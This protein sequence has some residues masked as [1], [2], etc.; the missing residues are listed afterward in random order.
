MADEI[1][2]QQVSNEDS[3]KSIDD[4]YIKSIELI[5]D[6]IDDKSST[7]YINT[8][9]ANR[10]FFLK[11]AIVAKEAQSTKIYNN[12]DE[13]NNDLRSL[14]E[15]GMNSFNT[16]NTS[17]DSVKW[18]KYYYHV[19]EESNKQ[20]I[21]AAEA[22]IK[23]YGIFDGLNKVYDGNDIPSHI[24]TLKNINDNLQP[25]EFI[26]LY[27]DS[28]SINY[29]SFY[30]EIP[31]IKAAGNVETVAP[32]EEAPVQEAPLEEA[33]V[34][35][36]PVEEAPVEE[37]PVQEAPVQ[38]APVQE[39]P[40]EE[41]PVQEAPVEETGTETPGPISSPKPSKTES[42]TSLPKT[43]YSGPQEQP[44]PSTVDG[45]NAKQSRSGKG[46]YWNKNGFNTFIHP[47]NLSDLDDDGKKLPDDWLSTAST[48]QYGKFPIGT[49][50]YF[51]KGDETQW[52]SPNYGI[53]PE[54]WTVDWSTTQNK[55]YYASPNNKSQ[56]TFPNNDETGEGSGTPT[57]Q[58][59]APAAP[60]FIYLPEGW[61]KRISKTTGKSLYYKHGTNETSWDLDKIPGYPEWLSKQSDEIKAEADAARK[62]NAERAANPK[63]PVEEAAAEGPATPTP[64]E[65]TVAE[66]PATVAEAPATVAPTSGATYLPPKWYERVSKSTGKTL[67]FNNET[68]ETSWNLDGIPGYSEWINQQGDEIQAAAEEAEKRDAE[69][70]STPVV[71]VQEETPSEEI[72]PTP[73][74]VLPA[75]PA[76]PADAIVKYLPQNWYERV[77]KKFGKTLY[78]NPLTKETHGTLDKIPGYAEWINRQPQEIKDAAE[79]ARK[80]NI[81]RDAN[82]SATQVVPVKEEI[83]PNPI[84]QAPTPAKST[85]EAFY[86]RFGEKPP[87]PQRSYQEL[88]IDHPNY[89]TGS[90]PQGI[91]GRRR[92]AIQNKVG[93]SRKRRKSTP[94]RR[95]R[96]N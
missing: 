40:V 63:L 61:T 19:S 65:A 25:D 5:K 34:Q 16:N 96:K 48:E 70:G 6:T 29:S 76:V 41:A 81:Q 11:V 36:A 92:H 21:E 56:W 58:L 2:N 87:K 15:A 30:P 84:P 4:L 18:Q 46:W 37:A 94:R 67:Y 3:I 93:G 69:R 74:P 13:I 57:A 75:A 8:I 39:A 51:N 71:P 64:Q 55:I 17:A 47:N 33:P 24:K 31:E 22:E 73:T 28:L 82:H 59:P 10:E 49:I 54:G 86:D 1:N 60:K 78:Y 45:W 79:L 12:I 27:P 20:L 53:L 9:E 77:S 7:E 83:V 88:P 14:Y 23:Q 72:V 50:Y 26:S 44:N 95:T 43:P 68:K 32:A 91:V 38:E 89:G 66:A 62:R 42:S 85:E 52:Y 35:E 90:I 80:R